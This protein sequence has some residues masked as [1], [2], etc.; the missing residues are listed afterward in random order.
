MIGLTSKHNFFNQSN[1]FARSYC[2]FFVVCSV[3]FIAA[4]ASQK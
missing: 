1:P 4:P 2:A 3:H